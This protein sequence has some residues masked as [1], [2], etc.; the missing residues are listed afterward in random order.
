MPLDKYSAANRGNWNDRVP[1]HWDSEEYHV[2]KFFK[3]PDRLSEI[4]KF[5]L[6]HGVLS[7]VEGKTLVHL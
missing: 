6:E 1:I 3:E 7:D 2:Q 4:V 5:V